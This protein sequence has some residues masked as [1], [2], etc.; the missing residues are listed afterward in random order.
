MAAK[1]IGISDG[2]VRL[3]TDVFG[4]RQA[5]ALCDQLTLDCAWQQPRIHLFG[6]HVRSPRLSAWYGDAA[7]TYSKITWPPQAWP[8]VIADIRHHLEDILGA[9]F[10][11]VLVNLY[12]DGQDSMGWHSDDEPELGA[13]PLIASLSFGAGRRFLLRRRDDHKMKCEIHLPHDSLLVMQGATQG[14]W[15]HALP[16]TARAVGPR[17]NLTFRNIF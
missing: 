1:Q 10:N 6:R 5:A 8:P 16:K 2:D 3:Y 9:V 11:G 13:S 17:I 15:Q 12:R 7:Y 4:D 14:H